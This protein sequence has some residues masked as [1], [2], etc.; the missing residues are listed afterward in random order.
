M[1]TNVVQVSQVFLPL[2]HPTASLGCVLEGFCNRR[3]PPAP[4]VTDTSYHTHPLLPLNVGS[5]DLCK[6]HGYT[7]AVMANRFAQDDFVTLPCAADPAMDP[8]WRV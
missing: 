6:Q 3:L 7:E 1:A 5:S 8:T 4:V 2:R